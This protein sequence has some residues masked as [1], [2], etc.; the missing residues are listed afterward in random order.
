[1]PHLDLT[2]LEM[3]HGLALALEHAINALRNHDGIDPRVDDLLDVSPLHAWP[4][5]S[6]RL[7]PVPSLHSRRARLVNPCFAVLEML[8]RRARACA[9]STPL[10]LHLKRHALDAAVGGAGRHEVDCDVLRSCKDVVC[11]AT[12]SLEM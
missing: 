1:M 7:S 4:V 8:R 3:L 6:A 11:V 10:V 2:T 5:P 12:P 9:H